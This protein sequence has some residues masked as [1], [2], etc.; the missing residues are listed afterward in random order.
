MYFLYRAN[1]GFNIPLTQLPIFQRTYY[2]YS[3]MTDKQFTEKEFLSIYLEGA[4]RKVQ[5]YK[6]LIKSDSNL[7]ISLFT[8]NCINYTA[9]L[10]LFLQNHVAALLVE[11]NFNLSLPIYQSSGVFVPIVNYLQLRSLGNQLKALRELDRFINQTLKES[12]PSINP[13]RE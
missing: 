8:E 5:E 12:Y 6:E 2:K 3:T 10:S 4:M 1:K 9:S 11:N 13:A 7:D